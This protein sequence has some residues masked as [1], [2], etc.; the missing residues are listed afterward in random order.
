MTD[1]VRYPG[2]D[3]ITFS[4]T[5]MANSMQ[6]F[7]VIS[8]WQKSSSLLAMRLRSSIDAVDSSFGECSFL[9]RF[10]MTLVQ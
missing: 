8:L 9:I 3:S 1:S 7:I 6:R 4:L 5:N 10:R 2:P